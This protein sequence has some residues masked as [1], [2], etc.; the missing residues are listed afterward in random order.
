MKMG[1]FCQIST[2]LWHLIYY[3]ISFRGSILSICR[4]IYFKLCKGVHIWKMWFGIVD[5]CHQDI[6]CICTELNLRGG[7]SCMPAALLLDD[8]SETYVEYSYG[9]LFV[10]KLWITCSRSPPCSQMYNNLPQNQ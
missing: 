9:T 2:E 10:L 7:V 5:G 8:E 1:N 4:P 6:M 3:T